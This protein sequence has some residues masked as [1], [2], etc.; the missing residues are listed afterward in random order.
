LHYIKRRL[1]GVWF[2][3]GANGVNRIAYD[4]VF[5]ATIAHVVSIS[6]CNSSRVF[7][8]YNLLINDLF[9]QNGRKGGL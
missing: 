3:L 9:T 7:R 8:K 1:R 6:V 4:K 5:S 2:F